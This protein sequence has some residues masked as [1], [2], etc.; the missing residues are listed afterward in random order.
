MA[1]IEHQIEMPKRAHLIK[2][3]KN[4]VALA[5]FYDMFSKRGW[6]YRAELIENHQNHMRAALEIHCII[7]P[8][9][10]M[11]DIFQFADKHSVALEF[12]VLSNRDDF[13]QI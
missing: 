3:E 12:I 5:S 6:F 4:K 1:D 2:E 9:L 8:V 7:K 11:K 10:E 13:K